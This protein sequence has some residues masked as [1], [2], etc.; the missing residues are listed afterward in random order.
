[1]FEGD[2]NALKQQ[3]TALNDEL[4]MSAYNQVIRNKR[5]KTTSK[6]VGGVL[7]NNNNNNTLSLQL[8]SADVSKISLRN[9]TDSSVSVPVPNVSSAEAP[10]L[11]TSKLGGTILKYSMLV[12]MKQRLEDKMKDTTELMEFIEPY[13]CVNEFI[14][15][16]HA[17]MLDDSPVEN[18]ETTLGCMSEI[19]SMKHM[20]KEQKAIIRFASG[21]TKTNDL[22]IGDESKTFLPQIMYLSGPTLRT[23][24]K[25]SDAWTK[26]Y[27]IQKLDK[28]RDFETEKRVQ[29]L[30]NKEGTTGPAYEETTF[31]IY[32][33]I[34][35]YKK[36]GRIR[37]VFWQPP[38]KKIR[39]GKS[40]DDNP[41]GHA[42]HMLTSAYKHGYC[43]TPS[44]YTENDCKESD[45]V[46][47]KTVLGKEFWE[48]RLKNFG[49]IN[50]LKEKE[51]YD[52]NIIKEEQNCPT[53]DCENYCKRNGMRYC[54]GIH[55]LVKRMLN[56]EL[57]KAKK[58]SGINVNFDKVIVDLASEAARI[59]KLLADRKKA[60]PKTKTV[61]ELEKNVQNISSK[62]NKIR[63][64]LKERNTGA[65][66]LIP[67][68]G[69]KLNLA[70][71]ELKQAR[72]T[73][74]KEKNKKELGKDI[75]EEGM[76]KR[77]K[78]MMENPTGAFELLTTKEK[79]TVLESSDF[80][81]KL[82]ITNGDKSKATN[83]TPLALI[84]KGAGAIVPVKHK[85]KLD[86]AVVVSMPGGGSQVISQNA[87]KKTIENNPLSILPLEAGDIISDVGGMRAVTKGPK[88][89]ILEDVFNQRNKS[90]IDRMSSSFKEI[91]KDL[92][93]SHAVV[94]DRIDRRKNRRSEEFTRKLK[95]SPLNFINESINKE[96][97]FLLKYMYKE[98]VFKMEST[99]QFIKKTLRMPNEP[100][101]YFEILY[102][103]FIGFNVRHGRKTN[104]YCNSENI[105][106]LYTIFK[107]SMN[108][109][110]N[111][112]T[113]FS[114]DRKMREVYQYAA[115]DYLHEGLLNVSSCAS[116]FMLLGKSRH[117]A[118]N[119][120]VLDK[121]RDR[122]L[123]KEVNKYTPLIS[124]VRSMVNDVKKQI[125]QRK[126][127]L[128]MEKDPTRVEQLTKILADVQ[129]DL[130]KETRNLLLL[131]KKR[132]RWVKLK[133]GASKGKVTHLYLDK[134][135][136]WKRNDATDGKLKRL[137]NVTN[138]TAKEPLS[139][140]SRKGNTMFFK[141]ATLLANYINYLIAPE[142]V[143]KEKKPKE[144]KARKPTQAH[145]IRDMQRLGMS[146]T[147]S[148]GLV[149]YE[150]ARQEKRVATKGKQKAKQNAKK[151][152]T[153]AKPKPKAKSTTPTTRPKARSAP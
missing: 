116:K 41:E 151:K 84:Q 100:C 81:S 75:S 40:L 124:Q 77:I 31:N 48:T 30:K 80:D 105:K 14:W 142:N 7:L 79:E 138:T 57:P 82:L 98:L 87:L 35:G 88:E 4:L 121:I 125:N 47:A 150:A 118:I 130:D 140:T 115:D 28:R 63:N 131:K 50:D 25:L 112:Q 56:Y 129:V 54:G 22:S 149:A 23:V 97:E 90:Y 42:A 36:G 62:V 38:P 139:V 104:E 103:H 76:Q 24:G 148:P 51:M 86:N 1:L 8:N 20:F 143:P 67:R 126:F 37:T 91:V 136:K 44:E 102:N 15:K 34:M 27:G 55:S 53:S 133:K 66:F 120:S 33:H 26:K 93:S 122:K 111:L 69:E 11:G 2:N 74:V 127:Q 3:L 46:I 52:L 145:R 65:T 78:N 110:G 135:K 132:D 73:L 32:E 85:G 92:N 117:V 6:G 83:T 21:L 12:T 49:L 119:P 96:D 128:E 5:S 95:F 146:L 152:A 10:N 123:Q 137:P 58:N 99:R 153:K 60:K 89:A 113:L 64:K 43:M 72:M 134:D 109:Q 101:E 106:K 13:K 9:I 68:G 19:Y 71:K 141:Q 45:D 144:R 108:I 94:Q 17:A 18:Y 114:S 29:G 107:T 61:K 147:A 59:K 70:E 16:Q 39:D